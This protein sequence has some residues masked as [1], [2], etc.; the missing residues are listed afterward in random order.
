MAVI[1]RNLQLRDINSNLVFPRASLDNIQRSKNDG[2]DALIVTL[3]ETG[4]ID[5]ALLPDSAETII[6]LKT[7]ATAAPTGA[8]AGDRYYNITQ[9]KIYTYSGTAWGSATTPDANKLYLSTDKNNI[10][11]YD[12]VSQMVDVSIHFTV[13][14][15]VAKDPIDASVTGVPSEYAVSVALQSKQD[16]VS[17]AIPVTVSGDG[18]V[19]LNY[20]S[21]LK[22][23]NNNLVADQDYIVHT[24]DSLMLR[25]AGPA[26]QSTAY[27]NGGTVYT[28]LGNCE[29]TTSVRTTGAQ[30]TKVPTEAAVRNAINAVVATGGASVIPGKAINVT[31]GSIN[32]TASTIAQTLGST[33]SA[34]ATTVT[35]ITQDD[36]SAI[37]PKS[38]RD[39]TSLGQAIDVTSYFNGGLEVKYDDVST[40][41]GLGNTSPHNSKYLEHATYRATAEAN[42]EGYYWI[43][44]STGGFHKRIA[45]HTYLFIA[46]IKNSGSLA[47]KLCSFKAYGSASGGSPVALSAAQL[48]AGQTAYSRISA[49]I[50]PSNGIAY[51]DFASSTNGTIM[52]EIKNL[53]V[54]DVTKLTSE[55]IAFLSLLPEPDLFFR[56][57]SIDNV[58]GR[59]AIKSDMVSPYIPIMSPPNNTDLTIFPG[60]AYSLIFT[61]NNVH[62]IS[63][64][65]FPTNACAYETFL[66]L[67]V[68]DASKVV[69]DG[70]N[71]MSPLRSNSGNNIIIK[72]RAGQVN[73]YV[74][75]TDVGYI[76]TLNS[77]SQN[78]SLAYGLGN[79]VGNYIVFSDTTNIT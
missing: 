10:Y 63:A 21:G 37:T 20:S 35:A 2:R 59:Y 66:Q 5:S 44:Y 70:I 19:S 24:V 77:G 7:V 8:T 26:D 52:V 27:V 33:A 79:N 62:R 65:T 67:T 78:G 55:A 9:N 60:R 49:I 45:G 47:L 4:H 23:T 16:R 25:D 69:F 42:K 28:I 51:I 43:G 6:M 50:N 71:L 54:Y 32:V 12:G 30:D 1:N 11:R 29:L 13:F 48:T 3:D 18:T 64:A 38:L 15:S 74:E 36:L 76:V 40:W 22:V 68:A 58:S 73:A 17:G 31:G 14:Q 75:D 57:S 39:A 34:N 61:D 53:R 56:D 41:A 72:F 46:D